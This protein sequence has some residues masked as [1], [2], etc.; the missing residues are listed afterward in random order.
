MMLMMRMMKIHV[1]PVLED[2]YAFVVEAGSSAMVIDPSEAQPVINLLHA[3]QLQLTHI[4]LTHYHGDHTGGVDALKRV[5]GADVFGPDAAST[6]PA[7]V[8]ITSTP[9]GGVDAASGP[10]TS[11]PETRFNASTPPV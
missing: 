1:L 9:A 11:A 8:S 10:K 5:S 6:P 7:G 2:N 4:L 3:R